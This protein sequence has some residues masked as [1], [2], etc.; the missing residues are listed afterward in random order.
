[1]KIGEVVL[2][3]TNSSLA[4]SS[5]PFPCHVVVVV[6]VVFVTPCSDWLPGILPPAKIRGV[7]RMA[8]LTGSSGLDH[9]TYSEH[10]C[11]AAG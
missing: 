6:V 11:A 9:S 2:W 10:P 7:L 4:L 8:G 3:E 5:F 1:M